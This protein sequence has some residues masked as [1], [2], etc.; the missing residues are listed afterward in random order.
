ME[1]LRLFYWNYPSGADGFAL[2][3]GKGVRKLRICPSVNLVI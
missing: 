2:E 1:F 3:E